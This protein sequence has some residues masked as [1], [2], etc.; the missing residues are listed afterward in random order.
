M[1]L[2]TTINERSTE[3]QKMDERVVHAILNCAAKKWNKTQAAITIFKEPYS[4]E[5]SLGLCVIT[6]SKNT[7]DNVN[8]TNA[9]SI[10]AMEQVCFQPIAT[11]K[12]D[13]YPS[14]KID[15]KLDI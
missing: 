10:H 7:M 9:V 14:L 8:N 5:M 12:L 15:L 11:R 1:D 3:Q 4:S 6:E 13:H 2:S